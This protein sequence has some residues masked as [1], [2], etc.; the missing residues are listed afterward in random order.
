MSMSKKRPYWLWDYDLTEAD[1]RRILAGKNKVERRWLMGRI[2][3][4]ARFDDVWKL[5][6]YRQVKTELSRLKLRPQIKEAWESA[7]AVWEQI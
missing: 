4:G 2:L 6:S 3:T 7:F 1:V 5:L